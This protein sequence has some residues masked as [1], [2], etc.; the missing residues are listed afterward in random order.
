MTLFLADE[1]DLPR[2]RAA[3]GRLDR[4]RDLQSERRGDGAGRTRAEPGRGR[5]RGRSSRI[6]GCSSNTSARARMGGR[7][8]RLKAAVALN[9]P[10]T[11]QPMAE[12]Y[13]AQLDATSC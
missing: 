9:D 13:Q 5:G 11:V 2:E 10:P 7:L 4:R 12:E 6:P 1:P 8:A 3:G